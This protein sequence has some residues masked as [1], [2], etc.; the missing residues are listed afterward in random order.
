MTGATGFLG[1]RLAARLAGGHR[2]VLLKR[3]ASDLS[4]LGRLAHDL[5]VYDLDRGGLEAALAAHRVEVIIHAAT[6]YGRT[7]GV[8]PVLMANLVLPARLA[9][10]AA[11]AGARAFINAD[12]VLPRLLNPYALAKVQLREWLEL[13]APGLSVVNLALQS[14]Y[15]PGQ[16]PEAFVTRTL[17]GLMAGGGGLAFTPGEQLRDFVYIDDVVEAFA[18]VLAHLDELGPGSHAVQV[19]SGRAV[20]IRQFVALAR[21]LTMSAARLEFGALAY[22]AGEPMR[23]CADIGRLAAWG[24]RPRVE[25]AEGLARTIAHLRAEGGSAG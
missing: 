1:S 21:E 19:G 3:S 13:L 12:T 14:F 17:A 16:G 10:A 15:G 4:R 9:E 24:W 23:C 25:L 11:S 22:R 5:P 18:A 7:G 6:D 8:E 20:S 2:L